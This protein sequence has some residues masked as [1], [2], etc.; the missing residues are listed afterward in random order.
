MTASL[1]FFLF[2]CVKILNRWYSFCLSCNY[3]FILYKVIFF[4]CTVQQTH[5]AL[6][7]LSFSPYLSL[8]LFGPCYCRLYNLSLPITTSETLFWHFL[9]QNNPRAWP[10]IYYIFFKN[11]LHFPSLKY[12]LFAYPHSVRNCAEPLP[13]LL[14][15][16]P[17]PACGK[18]WYPA[19][20]KVPIIEY[21]IVL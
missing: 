11:N 4:V 12:L 1:R 6:I 7:K 13:T 19:K 21:S 20:K 9:V 17:H 5:Q 18:R 8:S 14:Y 10:Y 15:R 16:L 2:S 3:D